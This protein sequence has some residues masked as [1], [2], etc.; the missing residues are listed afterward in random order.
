MVSQRSFLAAMKNRAAVNETAARTLKVIYP[1]LL[2]IGRFSH[3]IDRVGEHFNTPNL[4]EFATSWISLFSHNLILIHHMSRHGRIGQ[5]FYCHGS[6]MDF[7][8]FAQTQCGTHQK[9]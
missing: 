1:N 4:S 8:I 5:E 9:I 3:T 7:L 2:S 6:H